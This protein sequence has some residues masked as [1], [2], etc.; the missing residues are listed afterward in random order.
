M[1]T[2]D[3]KKL[4]R[5]RRRV[6]VIGAQQPVATVRARVPGK[7][8]DFVVVR[9]VFGTYR[10]YGICGTCGSRFPMRVRSHD[11]LSSYA[12]TVVIDKL[13]RRCMEY[14]DRHAMG[15]LTIVATP[16]GE[17]NVAS[18]LGVISVTR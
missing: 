3:W 10:A 2:Q 15:E 18:W 12:Y 14:R 16:V 4:A 9:S 8:A 1:T 17:Y 6:R 13:T 7:H 5:S 11:F